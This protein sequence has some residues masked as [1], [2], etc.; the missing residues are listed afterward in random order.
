MKR[1][2]SR[3]LLAMLGVF[4]LSVPVKAQSP[5]DPLPM[6]KEVRMG[7]L[8][9]GLT[10]YIRHNETPKGQADFYIAQKVGSILENDDQRGLA[11]FLEH[12][13]FNGT[14]NFPG[15]EIVKWLE[16]KGVKFGQNLNAYT[17]I[18]ETVY[19]IANV[20]TANVAVQ[21]SCLLILHDWADALLLE[22]AEIDKERGVIHEEWRSRNVGQMRLLEQLLPTMYPNSKYGYRLPIGT[23]EVVDNFPYKALR[24]YYESWYRPDQ[25][26]IVVVGDVDV[27]RIENKIKEMFSSIEMPANAPERKYEEVPDTPGT[28]FA[29]G[30]D[31]EMNNTN[32]TIYFKADAMPRE[33]RNSMAYL[34]SDYAEDM[35]TSML[36]SRLEEIGSKPD[37]PFAGAGTYYGNYMVSNTKDALAGV[38]I[39]KDNDAI[40]G[41]KAL[42][43]ELLRAKKGGFTATEYDRARKQYLSELEKQFNNREKQENDEYVQ[44]YI[45]NFIDNTPA[46]GIELKYQIMNMM[47]NQIPVDVINQG[48]AQM[49]TDDNRVVSVFMPAKEG[50]KVP[51]EEE[52]KKAMA[53]VEAEDIEVFVDQVKSE[54][55]IPA[56]PA[57]GKVVS[58]KDLPQW[59]ATE[60]TL[61]NGVK[62]VVKKTDFKADEICFDAQALVGYDKYPA[63]YDIT[64]AGIG[65][66][67]NQYS[68]GDY[69]W[70]D[71]QKYLQ[72]KQC[73]LQWQFG[74]NVS[75]LA[76]TTTPKD[77]PTMMELIYSFFTQFNVTKDD[78]DATSNSLKGVLANQ[79]TNPQY[80]FSRDLMK[81][82][83]NTDRRQPLSVA[84]LEGTDL[85][86][87]MQMV[88][89]LSA[90][91]ADYT[92]YFVGNI[93]LAQLRTLCEQY[94]ATLPAEAS[95]AANKLTF[96][97]Q[98]DLKTGN[99]VDNYTTNMENPQ[100]Y[101]AVVEFAELPYTA[102]DRALADAAGQILTQRLLKEVREDRGA[103]YS[104][105]ANGSM[106]RSSK[107]NAIIQSVFPMKPEMKQEVLD[108]IAKEFKNME[109][110]VTAEELAKVVEFEVKDAT[111]KKEK[112]DAWMNA[113]AAAA[114]N[115]VDTFNGNVELFKSLTPKDVMDFMK[116]INAGTY[117]VIILDPAAK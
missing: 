74:G 42:Y 37:A 18:D 34:I 65:A 56:L 87:G 23:M 25:Q 54:P 7:K 17:A 43:R 71:I 48:F 82:L 111:E 92:F 93:D 91:A 88:K 61:S 77:L 12:M 76:G 107:A 85:A 45:R 26:G 94:I 81:S 62:V 8:P 3:L 10:Y 6:D 60:W 47:A 35:I 64:I 11:H 69:S 50:V 20:P 98:Y 13:C 4:A 95:K 86:K 83:Y 59:G 112:N 97:P 51:T 36:N 102:K 44:E 39:A 32:I 53:E 55:L 96:Y 101:A 28:I 67:L 103:V 2:I 114:I 22:D 84:V 38:V 72:G 31:P 79:E 46:T 15:N 110:N 29:I 21:D 16:T 70:Q 117:R 9:N 73:S 90:N 1:N 115:G 104:I 105:W 80:V 41:F 113:M 57:P 89:E 75:D 19:N 58:E 30:S 100:T 52:M 106:G 63:D 49:I 27:D 78:F 108:I 116:K 33:I 14:K 109:S 5:T 40:K 66:L 99:G 68:L 24:D